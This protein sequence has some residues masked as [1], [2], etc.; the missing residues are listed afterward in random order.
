MSATITLTSPD[1][2][3]LP[4]YEARPAGPVRG[5]IVV[6][7]EIFG[8]NAHIRAV[9]DGYA[10]QGYLA[11][12]PAAFHRVRQGVELGYTQDD[13]QQGV[14]LKAAVQALPAPGVMADLETTVRHAAS[15]GKVG[16]VGYCWGGALVW[17]CAALVPGLSAAVAYYGGGMTV[18][19]ELRRQP[20]C[21][22]QCHFGDADHAIPN[23]TVAAFRAAQ[24]GVDVHVYAAQHGFNCDHRASYNAAAA[25]QALDRS[26]AF[27][28]RHLA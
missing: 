24:P 10:A 6:I 25:S 21:P 28:A 22:V 9:A 23:E 26:L 20:A 12:A 3:S 13:I 1:G 11:L 4:V 7:Q 8:V 2:F 27:F 5:A 18:G 17:R 19:D 16:T 14:A 15:A